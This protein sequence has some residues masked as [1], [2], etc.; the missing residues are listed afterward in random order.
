MSEQLK[1]TDEIV[2]FVHSIASL[3]NP[4][5][6]AI[7]NQKGRA[8]Y[9]PRETSINLDVVRKHLTGEQPIGCYFVLE[10]ACQVAV[11]DFDDH[12]KSMNWEDMAALAKTVVDR[13]IDGGFHPL[14]CR[15]G[16]G[17]G[18]HIWLF[19]PKPQSAKLMKAFLRA[20]VASCGFKHG[21]KGVLD[22]EV[23]VFPKNDRVRVGSLGNL[24]AL[25]YAR[26]SVPLDAD[27][28]PITW[29]SFVPPKLEE[30]YN[31]D[32][33]AN[34]EPPSPEPKKTSKRTCTAKKALVQNEVLPGDENEV[35]E[36]LKFVDADD[37]DT[38]ISYGL[39]IKNSL[40]TAAFDV[41]DE[42]ARRSAKYAEH[43]ES[44]SKWDGFEPD[45]SL[46]IGT[47][48][49][50]AKERGWKG[51]SGYIV[52][53]MNSRFGILT[54]GS[55]TRIILKGS[56]STEVLSWLGKGAFEDRLAP[57][58][59]AV[60]NNN[61]DTTWRPKARYWLQHPFAAHYHEVDFDSSL[62]PGHNGYVWN[63]W[64]GF[65]VEPIPG[66]WSRMKEHIFENICGGN[67]DYFNWLLNWL[68]LG[69][70]QP[71]L[72]IGTA[73][74]LKGLPGTGKGVLANAY[75][76][77]W[78]PHFVSITKDDHVRGRFNQHLEGRRF[79]YVDEAMF[80]GDRKNAGV[81]K[82]MLTEPQI[83][84][85]RKGVDPIWLNNH[86]IFMITSNERSV[87][88]ADIGDRRWQV[89]EVSDHKREDKA[90][91]SAI[92][93]QMSA[94]GYEAMLHELLDRDTSKGPDPRKTIRTPELFNEIIQAQG[95]VEKYLYQMLDT[96]ILPQPDAPGNGPGITTIAAMYSEIKRSH[97]GAQYVQETLFGRDLGKIFSGL[98][99]V[100]SGKFI[101]G[102][103]KH[104]E[105]SLARSM[106][107]HFPPLRDCRVMFEDYIG[108]PIPWTEDVED[109]QDDVDP[110]HDYGSINVGGDAPF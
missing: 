41:W 50:H 94:G 22:G 59:F 31:P 70:Q 13:L 39:A 107:Y 72:V 91:F 108:Q 27:L 32:V 77:L 35:R 95:P 48:F 103:T 12:D 56:T 105:P 26:Q 110:P 53:E 86:M 63:M 33:A 34:F 100:Q 25:P 65:A 87:V 4:K 9:Q 17:A 93:K 55:T 68:A 83:M 81:I 99:K 61:G 67:E 96:G 57:E 88:P 60:T 74:V 102:Y 29:S 85:E 54:Y 38:W 92:A 5:T 20:L 47:I 7:H 30:I 36:A 90:Y 101:T 28:K 14:C 78:M 76:Q 49:Q 10:D 98:R 19:W 64:H 21:T 40:G 71:A 84:I 51:P 104:G 69:V 23:E 6:H 79:V 1:I 3:G 8:K 11:I 80:G 43:D 2:T 18:L 58:K 109:W 37:Y 45:G 75:G 44:A 52:R 16:G 89:F 82:T 24:V 42:W 15:S 62:P 66:D 73:P 46:T 106:R 97:P